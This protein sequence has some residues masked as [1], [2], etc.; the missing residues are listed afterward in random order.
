MGER[1]RVRGKWSSRSK[2]YV[3]VLM[4]HGTKIATIRPTALP[5]LFPHPAL[6]PVA[7]EVEAALSRIRQ[8]L[9]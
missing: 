4:I 7:Q 5:G 9:A 1:A 8:D 6:A 3:S 2:K